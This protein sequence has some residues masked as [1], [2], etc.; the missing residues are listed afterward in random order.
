MADWYGEAFRRLLRRAE[1]RSEAATAR[2][3]RSLKT[4]ASR[5]RASLVFVTCCDHCFVLRLATCF[6]MPFLPT[7]VRRLRLT[8]ARTMPGQN[9]RRKH[10]KC[11]SRMNNAFPQAPA[12]TPAWEG[13]TRS[14]LARGQRMTGDEAM[15]PRS[16]E[17]L[18]VRARDDTAGPR[19]PAPL[20][21]PSSR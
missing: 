20:Y 1:R 16:Q 18:A 4:L 10:A 21:L 8:G 2:G 17:L 14:G 13:S 5:S 9:R 19:G 7:Q 3:L 15:E 12:S 11:W 6:F